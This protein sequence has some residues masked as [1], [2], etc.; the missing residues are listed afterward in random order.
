MNSMADL[1]HL[2]PPASLSDL[3]RAWLR[4]DSPAFDYGGLV[5]GERDERAVLLCKTPGVL[6]GA[7]FFQ[8]VF[9]ELGCNVEWFYHDG[10]MLLRHAGEAPCRVAVVTGKARH[11]L[12]AERPALNCLARAS[13]VAT[14]ARRACETARAAGWA[15]QVAGTRKTTPGFRLVEKH[16]LLVGGAATHRYDLSSMIM[17]KDNHVWSSGGITQAVRDAKRVGGF[18]LKVEV[19]C[20]TLEEG[21]EAARAG[22]DVIML[23]NVAPPMLHTHA[24]TLKS[25]FPT[26]VVEASGGVTDE[27]LLR[28]LGPSVDIVSLGSLTQ[29][30]PVVDFSLKVSRE[31]GILGENAV[32]GA[33]AYSA[34]NGGSPSPPSS[35][36]TTPSARRNYAF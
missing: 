33:A 12:L 1:S 21:R 9:H 36:A 11:L 28:Y 30:Y 26:V 7:P 4:E 35:S 24:Q 18:S 20:R 23:D 3:A 2:L 19:E 13:G 17:L 15:G 34:G 14:A 8:A 27:N 10:D 22:A 5:V 32:R 25:E 6:A 31:T 29:G 16:A